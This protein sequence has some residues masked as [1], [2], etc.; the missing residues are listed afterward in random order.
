VFDIVFENNT[1]FEPDLDL[2]KKIAN[3]LDAGEIELILTDNSE[4]Q[5]INLTTRGKDKP[6][7]VLSF[8]YEKMP[9]VPLGSIVISYDFIESYSKEYNHTL[10]EEFTLLFIHGLLH[11]LGFDHETDNGEHR[12]KEEELINKYKLPK[13]LI[14]RNT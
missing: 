4:I 14:I 5:E 12:A 3:D 2:A 6:T 9:N 8:P 1:D 7:D 13:S 11:L 10:N